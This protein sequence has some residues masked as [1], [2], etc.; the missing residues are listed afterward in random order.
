MN[1][2]YK[3]QGKALE[4]ANAFG[5]LYPAEVC[6]IQVIARSLRSYLDWP[7]I[8]VNIGAGTGTGSLALVEMR[9]DVKA[10]TVDIS[11][12]G[13]FGGLEN[14]RN[15]F[16]AAQIWPTPV[17]ILGDSKEVGKN[18]EQIAKDNGIDPMISYLFIDGDHS[19]EGLTGDMDG[20]LKWVKGNGYVLFHDYESTAWHDIT[21]II[22]ERMKP[23]RWK[24]IFHVDTLIVF[25][26]SGK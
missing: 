14:E 2:H 15:A 21:A 24:R 9:P 17:Q 25:Q 10:F 13:P 6:L 3:I 22:D 5:F 4:L 8:C 23:P 26:R 11:K 18:W 19:V 20:W 12:G 7:I 1:T 16:E